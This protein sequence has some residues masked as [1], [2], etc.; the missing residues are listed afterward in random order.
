MSRL[1][2]LDRATGSRERTHAFMEAMQGQT[3][4][5]ISHGKFGDMEGRGF[6][7]RL[8]AYVLVNAEVHTVPEKGGI[9]AWSVEPVITFAKDKSGVNKDATAEAVYYDDKYGGGLI[10]PKVRLLEATPYIPIGGFCSDVGG[11]VTAGTI[12]LDGEDPMDAINVE[13]FPRGYEEY[14]ASESTG[15][16]RFTLTMGAAGMLLDQLNATKHPIVP[17]FTR[18]LAAVL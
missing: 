4:V 14:S 8:R 16:T 6:S 13:D 1:Q 9:F 18:T 3:A 17:A 11:H 5:T 10:K 7:A 15:I 12:I 2:R